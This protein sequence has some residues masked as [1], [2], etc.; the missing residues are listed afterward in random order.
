MTR[1][2]FL[3]KGGCLNQRSPFFIPPQRLRK[4]SITLCQ[5]NIIPFSEKTL[6]LRSLNFESLI[7]NEHDR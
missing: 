1:H 7:T 6:T 4:L 5:K 2:M 3:K